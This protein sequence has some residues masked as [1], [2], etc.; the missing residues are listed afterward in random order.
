MLKKRI[1]H[2]ITKKAKFLHILQCA[3][4]QVLGKKAVFVHSKVKSMREV[5]GKGLGD[6]D[7]SS[8][9]EMHVACGM[10]N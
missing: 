1:V 8:L 10:Q 6:F 7:T 9:S 5:T 3:I 2:T 4:Y